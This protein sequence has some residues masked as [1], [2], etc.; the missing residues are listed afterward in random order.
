[1]LRPAEVENQDFG[2]G[3]WDLQ[4]FFMNGQPQMGFPAG[5]GNRKVGADETGATGD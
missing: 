3:N 1:V 4:G 5:Q 2:A